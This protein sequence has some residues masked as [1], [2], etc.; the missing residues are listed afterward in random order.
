MSSVNGNSSAATALPSLPIVLGSSSKFRARILAA[1]NIPFSVLIPNIDEKQFGGARDKANASDV[2]L[3]VARAKADALVKKIQEE[4]RGS[5][6]STPRLVVTCDQVVAWEG[7][8]REKPISEEVNNVVVP[9]PNLA[10]IH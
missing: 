7:G 8:V 3:A 2:V 10:G 5:G 1:H 4:E 9:L 6:T